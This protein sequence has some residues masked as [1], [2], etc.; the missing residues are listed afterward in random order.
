M[1]S[2]SDSKTVWQMRFTLAIDVADGCRSLTLRADDCGYGLVL[3]GSAPVFVQRVQ[4][5]GAA[6]KAGLR[7]GDFIMTVSL[8]FLFCNVMELDF[9]SSCCPYIRVVC[10]D[11]FYC[12]VLYLVCLSLRPFVGPSVC[13]SIRVS[14]V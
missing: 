3:Q 2:G 6:E 11:G 7:E 12:S 4:A 9:R 10:M 1:Q 5:G 8:C 13:L 14:E